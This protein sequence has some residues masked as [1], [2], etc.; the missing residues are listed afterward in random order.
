MESLLVGGSYSYSMNGNLDNTILMY[1]DGVDIPNEKIFYY[2]FSYMT[3]RV[4]GLDCGRS[5]ISY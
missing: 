4:F 1:V 5:I 3:G 2:E